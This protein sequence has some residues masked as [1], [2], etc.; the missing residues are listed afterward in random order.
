MNYR[1]VVI[2]SGHR[3]QV[4][5]HIQRI[6][7]KRTRAWQLRYGK[8]LTFSD[9]TSD[10]SGAAESLRLAIEELNKRIECLPAPTG[11]RKE[12]NSS[13]YSG[14]PI[15]ISGPIATTRKNR[16][17]TEYNFGVTIPRF[18][19]KPTTA[20]VYIGTENTVTDERYETAL[21]KAID[22]RRKAERAYQD[23]ATKA[24]RAGIS[25]KNCRDEKSKS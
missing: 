21:A 9:H 7:S 3:F 18:G 12:P 2:F 1:E 17:V 10:G 5:E 19:A 23:E 22:L 6:D 8:W 14:L 16:R 11:L 24:K 13:K 25:L 15:G 4:P 20:N